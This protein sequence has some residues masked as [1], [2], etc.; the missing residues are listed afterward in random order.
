MTVVMTVIV[1]VA[2]AVAVFLRPSLAAT[3]VAP[4]PASVI[5]ASVPVSAVRST[6]L[7]GDHVL[8]AFAAA[9][10]AGDFI[11]G[12]SR[13][14]RA[15]LHLHE[16][17]DVVVAQADAA[18]I[19]SPVAVGVTVRGAGITIDPVEQDVGADAD[20]GEDD[21]PGQSAGTELDDVARR[22]AALVRQEQDDRQVVID[23]L[24]SGQ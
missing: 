12:Q 11:G 3:I 5:P 6:S 19:L 4:A 22:P 2:M 20:P 23:V 15:D 24:Q 17:C 16:S 10:A 9:A 1:V 8:D 7:L 21:R 18:R 13:R 14:T